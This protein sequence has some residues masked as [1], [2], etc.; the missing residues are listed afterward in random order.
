M[1]SL[2]VFA[3]RS[4]ALAFASATVSPARGPEAWLR[5]PLWNSALY[6]SSVAA[7]S[8]GS[9]ESLIAWRL[10]ASSAG[11]WEYPFRVRIGTGP[12]LSAISLIWRE[13]WI[14]PSWMSRRAARS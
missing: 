7:S 13:T 4:K 1:L 8:F 11:T 6:S 3:M 12:S 5:M 9:M 2:A 10:T 14:L